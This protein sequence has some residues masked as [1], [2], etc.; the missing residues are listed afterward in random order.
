MAAPAP[1]APTVMALEPAGKYSAVTTVNGGPVNGTIT[2]TGKPGAY[3]GTFVSDALPEIPVT[4]VTVKG[5]TMTL[6]IE[7]PNGA[8]TITLNFTGAA[9]KG[10]WELAGQSGEMTGKKLP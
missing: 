9:Y 10:M 7:T 5:Q 1:A 3:T 8:A 2:I 4:A 6:Q